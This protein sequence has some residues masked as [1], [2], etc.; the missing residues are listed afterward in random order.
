MPDYFNCNSKSAELWSFE[1]YKQPPP[2]DPYTEAGFY[3]IQYNNLYLQ[4]DSTHNNVFGT[5]KTILYFDKKT[6]KTLDG[7]CFANIVGSYNFGTCN[8]AGA[9]TTFVF[10]KTSFYSPDLGMYSIAVKL[11]DDTYTMVPTDDSSDDYKIFEITQIKPVNVNPGYFQMES[12]S[13]S[14]YQLVKNGGTVTFDNS[15]TFQNTWYYDGTTFSIADKATTESAYFPMFDCTS[16]ADMVLTTVDKAGSILLQTLDDV[17]TF[18]VQNNKCLVTSVSNQKWNCQDTCM[19]PV[20]KLVMIPQPPPTSF[21]NGTYVIKYGDKCLGKDGNLSTCG[22][23]VGWVYDNNSSTLKLLDD[24]KTCLVNTSTTCDD[25]VVLTTGSCDNT[26]QSQ[27][28]ILGVDSTLYDKTCKNCYTDN[29]S[30]GLT[31]CTQNNA[32]EWSYTQDSGTSNWV[33]II[34]GISVLLLFI[35]L[36]VYLVRKYKKQKK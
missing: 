11:D 3:T 28:F 27:R 15:S 19:L 26:D 32:K 5:T 21:A 35:V 2:P 25:A 17:G 30:K 31:N 13:D 33:Y 36:G 6:L 23:Q 1:H 8:S 29:G 20:F 9:Y 16:P 10:N 34:I 22:D 12:I 4:P 14:T 24:S 18:I 7:V